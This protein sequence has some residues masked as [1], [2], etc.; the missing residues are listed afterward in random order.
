MG[1]DSEDLDSRVNR[2]DQNG[3]T[4][5][6]KR[7]R[8]RNIL[9]SES[10]PEV[11]DSIISERVNVKI[12]KNDAGE[13]IFHVMAKNKSLNENIEGT[14]FYEKVW[15]PF[16][17]PHLR[18]HLLET[19]STAKKN[20][21]DE[22]AK[23]VFDESLKENPNLLSKIFR[24]GGEY[25][26]VLDNLLDQRG[27]GILSGKYDNQNTLLHEAVLDNNYGNI[28]YL[29]SRNRELL[30]EQND[31]GQT[32]LHLAVVKYMAGKNDEVGV[33]GKRK[34]S[35]SNEEGVIRLLSANNNSLNVRDRD[36]KTALDYLKEAG[37]EEDP[38]YGELRNLGA[39][40]SSE[41]G[42]PVYNFVAGMVRSLLP[43][44]DGIKNTYTLPQ[45]KPK[46]SEQKKGPGIGG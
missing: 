10:L 42:Y 5:L 43:E 18:D 24:E 15:K 14:I 4:M 3:D 40:M 6:H 9:G 33:N 2:C 46:I 12:S 22:F 29:V 31:D 38:I 36:G 25:K 41:W 1:K 34:F 26:E 7:F 30:H 8:L 44:P 23:F 19:L 13:T 37:L 20:E 27:I 28:E 17:L 35:E 45:K 11:V 39:K 16:V 32:P 21:N